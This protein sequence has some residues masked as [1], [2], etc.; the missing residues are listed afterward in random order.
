M[1]RDRLLALKKK[2]K[3]LQ[4]SPH[5]LCCCAAAT[6]PHHCHIGALGQSGDVER[7]WNYDWSPSGRGVYCF[8]A[9]ATDVAGNVEQTAV[10]GPFA[11]TFTPSTSSEPETPPVRR[12]QGQF[13][14]PQGS[15]LGASTI[16]QVL[17][18]SCGL[19]M[20]RFVRLGSRYNDSEQVSK[21]QTFLNKQ[22]G[23]NLPITGFYGPLTLTVVKAFQTKYGNEILTPWGI[24]APTGIVYQT[25]LRW[26][27]MLE[28]P[29]LA[30]QIP[31]LVNW[32]DNPNIPRE[33]LAN[34]SVTT[35]A[36]ATLSVPGASI[37]E[38]DD[39]DTKTEGLSASAVQA[40]ST[41][42]GFFN[43]LKKFLGR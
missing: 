20:D 7:D 2:E 43:F 11:Y 33:P 10:A 41:T 5:K 3:L 28:C 4:E 16:G 34:V 24:T 42:G 14:Q 9:H 30:L 29:D 8:V 17:G 19:Y 22:M 21:L 35:G 36:P 40:E 38:Q 6:L 1:H 32:S 13:T 37:P 25:T 23:S 27:N 15:V 12:T 31:P 26:V 39:T 18:Q